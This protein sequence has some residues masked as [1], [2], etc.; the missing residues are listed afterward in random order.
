MSVSCMLCFSAY[1]QLICELD[2]L[3]LGLL[4]HQGQ[5]DALEL[6][7]ILQVLLAAVAGLGLVAA[8]GEDH[9]LGLVRLKP[10]SIFLQQCAR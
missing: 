1:L 5:D 10:G 8:L 9:Q 4:M 3:Q 2:G 7:H 6:G